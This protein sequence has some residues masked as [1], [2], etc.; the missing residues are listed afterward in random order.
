MDFIDLIYYK[1]G[2][3]KLNTELPR[4]KEINRT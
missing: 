2:L 3:L 1:N 4:V